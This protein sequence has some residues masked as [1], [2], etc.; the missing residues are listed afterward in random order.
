MPLEATKTVLTLDRSRQLPVSGSGV[1]PPVEPAYSIAPFV[2][3]GLP[4]RCSDAT[5][6]AWE[7]QRSPY[8][9]RLESKNGQL[10]PHGQDALIL[11]LVAT[12]AWQQTNCRLCLGSAYQILRRLGL[13]VTGA[14]YSRLSRRLARFRDCQVTTSVDTGNGQT[15]VRSYPFFENSD[16]WFDRRNLLE[17]ARKFNNQVTVSAGFLEDLRR[18]PVQ[19]N[20]EIV[21][22][23][24]NAPGALDLSLFI[25]WRSHLVRSGRHVKVPLSGPMSLSEQLNSGPYL[26]ERD[27]RRQVRTW[28]S[29]L[30]HV[31]PECPA[32]LTSDGSQLLIC[33]GPLWTPPWPLV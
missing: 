24:A 1:A 22:G 16:F 2:R 7:R 28:I 26:Q 4:W 27:R 20:M 18:F 21:R 5:G 19:T 25:A 13:S 12:S 11:I 30:K 15:L 17:Q 9:V 6:D 32:V 14:D 10:L 31:W 3:C 29:K 23:L 33:H 8:Q